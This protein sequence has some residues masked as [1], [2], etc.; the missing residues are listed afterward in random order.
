MGFTMVWIPAWFFRGFL[1]LF[2]LFFD[3]LDPFL[4]KIVRKKPWAEIGFFRDHSKSASFLGQK[5]HNLV[6]K[7]GKIDQVPKRIL[8]V[9]GRELSFWHYLGVV[10]VL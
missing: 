2:T 6:E 4:S 5:S 8:S 7:G 3:F 1:T 9:K 10:W